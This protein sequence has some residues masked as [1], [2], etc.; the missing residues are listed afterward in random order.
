M[1]L[2][3]LSSRVE[4]RDESEHDDACDPYDAEQHR[5]AIEVA[6][7]NAGRSQVR[8]DA[9]TEH[10]GE[11]ATVTTVQQDQEG[12][13]EAGDSEH[14]L[15]DD[16]ENFHNVPFWDASSRFGRTERFCDKPL[17]SITGM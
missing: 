10:V 15:Q 11:A 8:R 3:L 12:Q 13:Q 1:P 7:R 4:L 2:C 5:N 17:F 9:T 14:N 6:L 16:L